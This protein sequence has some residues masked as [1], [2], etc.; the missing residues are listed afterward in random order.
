MVRKSE[1][2]C[3]IK[4]WALI[5]EWDALSLKSLINTKQTLPGMSKAVELFLYFDITV[6]GL[7]FCDIKKWT[8]GESW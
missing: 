6:E 3:Y 4:N 2:R 1:T 8:F 5:L 7:L